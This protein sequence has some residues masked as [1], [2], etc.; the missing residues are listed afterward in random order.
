LGRHEAAIAAANKAVELDPLAPQSHLTLA[1]ALLFA[2][3]YDQAEPAVRRAIALAS[4]RPTVHGTLGVILLL[5]QHSEESLVECDKEKVDWLR[6][7]CRALVFAATARQDLARAEMTAMLKANNVGE[8]AAYQ[9]AEIN[10]QLDD[11]DEAF[12]WLARAREIRDP[13]LTGNVFVDPFLDPLRADPRYDMLIREL[14]FSAK[15]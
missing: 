14:G 9:Y 15:G 10:A 12:R 1:N 8:A 3:R 6:M 4:D 7:T 13:G 11:L 2:R 5:R